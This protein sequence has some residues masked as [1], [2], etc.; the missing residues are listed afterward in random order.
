VLTVDRLLDI[1]A[2]AENDYRYGA[3]YVRVRG[4][5]IM[6]QAFLAARYLEQNGEGEVELVGPFGGDREIGRGD[7][8]LIKK[9]SAIQTTK[10]NGNRIAGRTYPVTLRAV[11]NGSIYENYGQ[12]YC[13]NRRA[14]WTSDGYWCSTDISN[15]V[16]AD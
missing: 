8:V 9:G 3:G 10:K 14:V 2:Q 4:Y 6:N 12:I 5:D 7:R 13:Q 15:V 1:A 16:K 11:D